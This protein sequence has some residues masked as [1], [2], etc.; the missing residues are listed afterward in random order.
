MAPELTHS[1]FEI[2]TGLKQHATR[3]QLTCK[4]ITDEHLL[5]INFFTQLLTIDFD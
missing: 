5:L 4:N 2:H 1:C 3:T